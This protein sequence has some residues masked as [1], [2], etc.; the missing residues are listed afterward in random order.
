MV[1]NHIQNHRQALLVTG[2]HQSFQ[3]EGPAVGVVRCIQVHAVIT[4]SAVSGEFSHGHDLDMRDPEIHQMVQALNG[5]FE[6]ARW[7]ER[8]NV[9][10][11]ENRFG[12]RLRME[13]GI[14]PI[15]RIMIHNA[16]RSMN[17]EGLPARP[18]VRHLDAIVQQKCVIRARCD[19]RKFNEPPSGLLRQIARSRQRVHAISYSD[20]DPIDLGSPHGE[21]PK[22]SLAGRRYYEPD[23]VSNTL[24]FFE[25][26]ASRFLLHEYVSLHQSEVIKTSPP[27]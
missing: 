3:T 14:T 26:R 16:G 13:L 25:F 12:K 22:A 20:G 8:T 9:Q 19:S 21:L 24:S 6:G 5:R 11:I 7:R 23:S 4:P 18:R 1:V 2:I 10:L 27:V 15:E 17:S